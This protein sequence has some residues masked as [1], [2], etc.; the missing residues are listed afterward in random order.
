M[1]SWYSSVT[2]KRTLP[3]QCHFQ[4]SPDHNPDSSVPEGC[5]SHLQVRSLALALAL[6]APA[7]R[8]A[9]CAK[10][11]GFG[12]EAGDAV[13]TCRRCVVRECVCVYR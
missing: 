11:G 2:C 9:V 3:I 10:G 7:A 13:H 12:P 4:P 6:N 8:F 5:Y 1:L